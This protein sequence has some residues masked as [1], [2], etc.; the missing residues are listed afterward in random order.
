MYSQSCGGKFC[1]LDLSF[2]LI[3]TLL[4][5]IDTK[6]L[7]FVYTLAKPVHG[8]LMSID[9]NSPISGKLYFHYALCL[10]QKQPR[11]LRAP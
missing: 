3:G 1:F 11:L 8:K 7:T 2:D 9:A 6:R 5:A 10:Y 4:E